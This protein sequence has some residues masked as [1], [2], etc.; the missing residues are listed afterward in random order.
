MAWSSRTRSR[1]ALATALLIGG[2][3]ACHRD[4]LSSAPTTSTQPGTGHHA[5]FTNGGRIEAMLSVHAW[6]TWPDGNFPPGIS[7]IPLEEASVFLRDDPD[8]LAP[9]RHRRAIGK[10][11]GYA[12]GNEAIRRALVVLQADPPTIEAALGALGPHLTPMQ[13][14]TFVNDM[15]ANV[16][17]SCPWHQL[18]VTPPIPGA[19]QIT[20]QV[21]IWVPRMLADA[22]SAFD[23]QRWDECSKFFSPPERTFL[24]HLDSNNQ[25]VADPALP[26]GSAIPGRH[27]YESFTCNQTGCSATF[28]N[29]LNITSWYST[30]AAGSTDPRCPDLPGAGTSRYNLT[31]SL[32]EALGGEV[33]GVPNTVS[34]DGGEGCAQ[35]DPTGGTQAFVS[36]TI[37]FTNPV[38]NGINQAIL[39]FAEVAGEFADLLCCVEATSESSTT[40][41]TP[42]AS[43][44]GSPNL[45]DVEPVN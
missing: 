11:A 29:M 6:A 34:I 8:R 5:E 17:G 37:E 2:F 33:L 39:T 40:L 35:T 16:S 14:E 4:Q 13:R 43:G 9:S 15:F 32:D 21:T 23:P 28:Q 20:T 18:K 36:K 7:V 1:A 19:P 31:Y 45:T 41:P 10:L 22:A 26:A 42:P 27:L 44:P 3:A 30:P 25:P 38:T 24:A 12:I